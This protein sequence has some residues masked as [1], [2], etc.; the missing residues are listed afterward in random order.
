MDYLNMLLNIVLSPI[1]LIL[2]LL[3]T[4]PF[5]SAVFSASAGTHSSRLVFWTYLLFCTGLLLAIFL[6]VEIYNI[7]APQKI[8]LVEILQPRYYWLS[9][10]CWLITAFTLSV[11]GKGMEGNVLGFIFFPI[12]I[13]ASLALLAVNIKPLTNSFNPGGEP[14]VINVW[15]AFL[16]HGFNP[17]LAL[18]FFQRTANAD[19]SRAPDM[20]FFTIIT[21]IYICYLFILGFHWLLFLFSSQG[22]VLTEFWGRGQGLVYFLPFVGGALVYI[23]YVFALKEKV[24]QGA[25]KNILHI[26]F[27]L[28][29]V[30]S[31]GLQFIN[32]IQYLKRIY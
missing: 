24:R 1:T 25:L 29:L 15:L 12:L 11:F 18:L 19:G 6:L 27:C 7:A 21:S 8:T 10:C 13:A 14:I 9:L 4:T 20:G 30:V 2:F 5:N 16:L 26:A 23:Y 31:L 17:L 28:T 3:V 32:Y 22:L